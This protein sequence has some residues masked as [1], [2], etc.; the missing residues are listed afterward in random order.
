MGKFTIDKIR[1]HLIVRRYMDKKQAQ[2]DVWIAF[3]LFLLVGR[4]KFS[5]Q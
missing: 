2:E 1:G 5:A 4:E 3:P